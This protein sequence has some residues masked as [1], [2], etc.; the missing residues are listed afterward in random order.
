M[1]NVSPIVKSFALEEAADNNGGGAWSIILMVLVYALVIGALWFFM[2]RPQSK[3]RK[4]EEK[5]RKNLQVGDDITTIGGIMGKVISI[6]EETDSLVIETGVDRSKVRVKR[7]AVAS[8][9][10]IHDDVE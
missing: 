5:M 3:K 10:T 6:K 4:K 7:W 1:L 2:M 8:C 9:D